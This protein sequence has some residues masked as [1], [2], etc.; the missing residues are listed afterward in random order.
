[1][2]DPSA[3]SLAQ[4]QQFHRQLDEEKQ[5]NQDVL[6]NCA[7]LAEE[8]GELISA[9]RELVAGKNAVPE[10]EARERVGAE[11]ADCLAYI[12]KLANYADVELGP[13]YVR[14]MAENVDRQWSRR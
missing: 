10:A 1:M 5:F 3:P 14:K 9:L 13:A 2:L 11:L 12:A 7:Y 8:V 6:A 4:M